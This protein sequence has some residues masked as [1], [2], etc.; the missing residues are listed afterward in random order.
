MAA[1]DAAEH[2]MVDYEPLP[3]VTTT[4]AAAEGPRLW[5]SPNVCADTTVG[6]P[7]EDAFKRAAHVV[8]L[9]TSMN[10]VTG[11]PMEPR[12]ALGRTTNKRSGTWSTR[13]APAAPCAPEIAG[14]LG[15][16]ERSTRGDARGSAATTA[17]ATTSTRSSRSSHRRRAPAPP[18]Q[19]DLRAQ[20]RLFSATS[21]RATSS[22]APSCARRRGQLPRPALR[23]PQQ[24]RGARG[25]VHPAR[26]GHGGIDQRVPLSRGGGPRPRGDEHH[27]ADDALPRRRR[28]RRS[29]S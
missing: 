21:I 17:R 3:A 7:V 20:R 15:V 8:A 4:T 22:R 5:D 19:M 13:P 14:A 29:C 18:G 16:P 2:V 9:Q 28:G 1:K 26:Q 27:L 12:A 10:R 23:S 24:R 6:S 11:V 25:V